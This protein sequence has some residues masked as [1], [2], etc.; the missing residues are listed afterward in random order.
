LMYMISGKTSGTEALRLLAQVCMY[1]FVYMYMCFVLYVCMY[2]CV[3][4]CICI[5]VYVL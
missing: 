1:V 5:Y 4:M 3:Y 2:V